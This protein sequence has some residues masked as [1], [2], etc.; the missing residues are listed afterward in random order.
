MASNKK[1]TPRIVLIVI[2][3]VVILIAASL[4]GFLYYIRSTKDYCSTYATE[5]AK[6]SPTQDFTH[7]E[8]YYLCLKDKGLS[9]F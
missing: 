2:V 7:S 8:K 9:G 4:A 6:N 1:R 3:S 5:Q